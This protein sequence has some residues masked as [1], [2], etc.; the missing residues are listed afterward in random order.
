[1]PIV[2]FAPFQSLV[3]PALWHALTDLKI[4]ILRLSN[5]TLPVTAT[6]SAGRAVKFHETGQ[7][8]VLGC[9]LS[10]AADAFSKTPQCVFFLSSVSH[11]LIAFAFGELT[12]G[13]CARCRILQNAVSTTG[14]FKNFNTIEDFKNTDKSALFNHVADETWKSIIEDRSTAHL[15]RFLLITF[16]DLKKYKYYYWFAFPAFTAKPA[17][18]IDGEWG[19]AEHTLG[20]DVVRLF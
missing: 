13:G 3:Q 11:P 20:A 2:Q 16:A 15:T 6:Y 4:D 8:I 5:A 14:S 12:L 10:L 1:M 9:N 18:E 17:W 19:S 7:E